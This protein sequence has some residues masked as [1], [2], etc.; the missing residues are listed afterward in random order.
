M[1]WWMASCL[2]SP[3]ADFGGNLVAEVLDVFGAVFRSKAEAV[4]SGGDGSKQRHVAC[5]A[6]DLLCQRPSSTLSV[7]DWAVVLALL[8]VVLKPYGLTMLLQTFAKNNC[9]LDHQYR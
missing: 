5:I 6:C 2:V 7:I 3:A 4:R 8:A 9:H 1:W